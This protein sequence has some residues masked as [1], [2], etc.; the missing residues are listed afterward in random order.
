MESPYEKDDI[1]MWDIKP[2]FPEEF[3]VEN[4]Q[5]ASKSFGKERG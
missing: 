5:P 2:F 1:F 4:M 3:E